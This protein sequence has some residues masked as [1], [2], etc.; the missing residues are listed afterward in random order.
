MMEVH[1]HVAEMLDNGNYSTQAYLDQSLATLSQNY[2]T[3]T[4]GTMT[5][6]LVINKVDLA[7]AAL[8]FS[9]EPA[10]GSPAFKFYT[11][12]SDYTS[13]HYPTFGTTGKPSELA[14]NFD[15][16]EDFC[17]IYSDTNKV[18]SI[19]KDG[20]ACSTLIL[21]DISSN[22]T[23][24]IIHNKIDLKERIN[25][26]KA[27]FQ[28]MRQGVSDATDFDTLKATILTALASV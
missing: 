26:Y 3:H 4:G 25:S 10:S 28:Q 18:F 9:D 27:A 15:G 24:R 12:S 8:D 14:W 23:G 22:N 20:P 13:V 1:T 19:T 17:W 11:Q 16:D 5:G 7:D 21:G 6:N 2:L